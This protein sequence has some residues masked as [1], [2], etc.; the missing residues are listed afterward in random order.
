M[1]MLFSYVRAWTLRLRVRSSER[2][3]C[4]SYRG[5]WNLHA[6]SAELPTYFFRI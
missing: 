1:G 2:N 6:R 3:Y 5:G 4:P